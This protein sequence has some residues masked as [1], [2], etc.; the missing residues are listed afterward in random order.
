MRPFVLHA[1]FYQPERI[2]PWTQGLDPE[3][4]AA[5]D[6]D[7]NERI[8]RECY[9]PNA[10]ARIYDDRGRVEDLV[11]N[12]EFL[13]FNFGPTLLAWL[14]QRHPDTYAKIIDGD[15]RSTVRTGHGNALAQAF[16]HA[17]L[18]L[19]SARDR[20]TEIRWGLADFRWRFNRSPEGMWLPEAAVDHATIDALIDEGVRFTV[21]APSQA[22]RVRF[23]GGEWRDAA[24]HLDR[25]RSYRHAH[26]DGS[27]RSLAI[28]FYDGELA[29]SIAFDAAT[30]DSAVLLHRILTAAGDGLTHAAFD[31]ETFGH[32]HPFGELGLAYALTRAAGQLDHAPT[33]YGAYLAEHP[34]TDEVEIVAG[35]G[36]SW[37]CAH[38]VGRWTRDCGCSTGGEPGWNQAWRTPL[39]EALDILRDVAAEV[40]EGR[41]RPLLRDVWRARD[42]Y[43]NVR[44]G[45][46]SRQR[47]LDRH[48]RRNLSDDQLVELWTLLESQRHA[49]LMYTSCGWFFNDIAG[50]ETI[51][52]LRS[53]ARVFGLLDAI[54]A[55][56]DDGAFIERLAQAKSNTPGAGTGA[57]VWRQ[58]IIAAEMRPHRLAANLALQ[59]AVVVAPDVQETLGYHV[60]M[61]DRRQEERGRTRLLTTRVLARSMAT[62]RRLEFAVAVLH[63]G[64]LDFHGVVLPEPDDPTWQTASQRIWEAFPTAPL[65]QLLRVIGETLPGTEFTLDAALPEGR[66]R[67]VGEIFGHLTRLFHE[68]YSRL[69]ADHRRTL[70]M[71]TAAG[72][73]LPRD[74]RAAAELTLAAELE[75]ALGEARREA[76]AQGTRAFGGVQAIL[77]LARHQGYRIED[78]PVV[79]ALTTAVTKAAATAADTLD[80]SSVE[81]VERWLGLA[82]DLQLDI[83]TT[84]AQER[85]FDAARR[86]RTGR[87]SFDETEAAARL[88]ARMGLSAV[89]WQHH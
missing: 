39:R 3:P 14:E 63:L 71:L 76:A 67:I 77:R 48:A 75:S 40:F 56:P 13:S 72:Y 1:H 9:R 61:A 43:I 28:F 79:Q 83:D 26:S 47:F 53:A 34:P 30:A 2:N 66:Q 82:H 12:Y 70:E 55:R 21:L 19:A 23:D 11:N 24:E 41:G 8:Y 44:L 59:R 16:H 4:T 18:P 29:Q 32:H 51:Y 60:T 87:L 31:G 38:G 27:G 10:L 78:A 84:R 7:W 57:D 20:R 50:I 69:Y 42:D 54:G 5:P 58:Q 86:A 65:A 35:E 68:S 49:L 85:A 80:A 15:W 36:S 33:S 81:A 17:I 37:S 45:A 62:G 25:G 89:A 73:E 52:V 88:G 46:W 64:G 6:R 74:L 22:A